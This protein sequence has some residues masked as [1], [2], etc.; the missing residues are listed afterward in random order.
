[1]PSSHHDKELREL[2]GWEFRPYTTHSIGWD[3]RH[4]EMPA[5]LARS[6]LKRLPG[7]IETA[8]ANAAFLNEHLG[9]I[10]GLIP[11][12]VPDDRTSVYY[13][14]RLRFDPEVLG[15]SVP[16]QTFR[17]ILGRA[18]LAEGLDA[19]LW[20]VAPV[21]SDPLFRTREGLGN[22]FPWTQPPASRAVDYEPDDYP[23]ALRMLDTSLCVSD[24][25]HPLFV[26]PREVVAGDVEGITK[27]L[28][29]PERLIRA[30][31]I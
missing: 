6:L 19:M 23:D 20:H 24:A 14:Y 15:F 4:Q 18:L 7:Y 21:T 10:P 25:S 27:V 2:S 8:Q 26:Q 31:R 9:K 12:S 16:A 22:G 13:L 30:S 17:D 5:A 3:Y 11:P 1:M 29:D 28:A